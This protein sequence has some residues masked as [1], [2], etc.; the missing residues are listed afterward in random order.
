MLTVMRDKLSGWITWTIIVGISLVFI[1]FGIGNYFE[2]GPQSSRTVATVGDL[3]ISQNE[4][5]NV[6]NNLVSQYPDKDNVALREMA[7]K[8]L[9]DSKL[10]V[11][12]AEMMGA[13]ISTG[14]LDQVIYGIPA[15]QENNQFSENKFQYFISKSGL[16]LS[17]IRNDIKDNA[18]SNQVAY[19]LAG[20]IFVL[21]SEM[22]DYVDIMLQ[23]RDIKQVEFLAED[24][25]D[26]AIINDKE[27]DAYYQNHNNDFKTPAKVSVDYIELSVDLL[28]KDIEPTEEQELA[29]YDS[30]KLAFYKPE[31]REYSQITLLKSDQN[32]KN[33]NKTA[34]SIID[35][36]KSGKDFSK[37]VTE[38]SDD[39]LAKKDG[40]KMGWV[41][42]TSTDPKQE[43]INNALF[44]LKK[45]GDTA[46]IKTEDGIEIIKLTGIKEAFQK[47]FSD[48]KQE[49]VHRI[50]SQKAEREYSS[51]GNE[52]SNLAFENP[53]SLDFVAKK[54]NLKVQTTSEFTR[55]GEKSGIASNQQVINSAFSDN[56][57]KDKNNSDPINISDT[58]LV[59][60][61]L[62][63]YVPSSVKSLASVKQEISDRLELQKQDELAK[64]EAQKI[65]STLNSGEGNS[66]YQFKEIKAISRDSKLFSPGRVQNYMSAKLSSTAKPN[67]DVVKLKDGYGVFAVTKIT[68]PENDNK[69][70]GMMYG[71]LLQQTYGSY[72]YQLYLAEIKKEIPVEINN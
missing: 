24:F 37:L 66:E 58:E 32:N 61:H 10:K 70:Q 52:M 60:I 56:V 72:I 57:L 9:I 48:V 67:F 8:A 46:P 34:E 28:A 4:L 21:P 18:I 29:Y 71:Q 43:T 50:K 20:S 62:R 42:V 25:T 53:Q 40:G 33:I 68:I 26:R 23:K 22:D 3:N 39:I 11:V 35:Q 27:I 55:E 12:S 63:S 17:E 6:M 7:L 36:V 14:Q 30:N 31:T 51:L 13:N 16:S 49:I 44:A 15:F 45:V 69:M 1:L 47:S 41:E 38:Y 64:Q 54:L 65:A 2:S 5:N 19:G 59:I